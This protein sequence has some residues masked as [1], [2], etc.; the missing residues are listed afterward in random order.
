MTKLKQ[1]ISETTYHSLK[2]N[3]ISVDFILLN[4][5]NV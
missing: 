2:K 1:L 4:A 3:K 5:Y